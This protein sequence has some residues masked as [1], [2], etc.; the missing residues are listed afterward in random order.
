[1]ARIE[2]GFQVLRGG[3][4]ADPAK[5]RPEPADI[6][7]ADGVIRE[8]GPPGLVAP[9][10]TPV[11]DAA[12]H[13]LHPGLVNAHTHGHG[14]LARGQGDRW[15]L[16]LLLAAAPWIG[17]ARALRDKHL[18]TLLCAAEMVLKGCT[19]AYDLTAEVPL[20]TVEGLDAMAE[21]YAAVGMRA[22]VAPMVAD[23]ALWD[24]LPGLFDA[25]PDPLREEVRKLRAEPHARTLAA[26]REALRGWRWAAEDIRFALGPTIPLHCTDAFLCG[27]RDLAREHGVGLHTHVGESRAQALEGVR[28]YGRTL[29]AHL[30]SL[31]LLSERFTAAHGVWLDDDDLRRLADRGASLAHNPGSN[32]KLGNGMARLTRALEL[33]VNVGI[34][35]DGVSSGDNSN[36]YEAARL[37]ALVSH[38][39]TPD[40][41]RWASAEACWNAATR[42][43]AKA[44]GF[45]DIGEI[46]PGRKADIVFLDLAVPHWIP[47][48]GTINQLVHAEDATAVRHVMIGGRMVVRDRRL[49]TVDLAAL[50]V[51]A[52]AARERLE[53]LNAERRGLFERLEPAVSRFCAGLMAQPYPISRFVCEAPN[54]FV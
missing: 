37:A 14:G 21:A 52:E 23:T 31:G 4:L 12:G 20:P 27:C 11:V 7:I 22:V 38:A 1:M 2:A 29:V 54:S 42:G 26:M 5:R 51:E 44:L 17:G 50:A 15:T 46:A 39:Q 53:T 43:S 6:L 13:L 18:S 3:K 32:M 9:E 34:G 16:E 33:G 28:R 19:A 45:D 35:T 48:N 49:L 47:A 30:D 8:I 25:L 10:G 24:A 40:V 36:M 41:S